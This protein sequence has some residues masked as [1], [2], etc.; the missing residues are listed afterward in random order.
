MK[1][2]GA[3]GPGGI[4]YANRGSTDISTE[5]AKTANR[6]TNPD[7]IGVEDW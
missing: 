3:R 7:R 2:A 6:V 5:V 4:V 1:D